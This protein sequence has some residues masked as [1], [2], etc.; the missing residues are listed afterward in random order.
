[1]RLMKLQDDLLF[2]IDEAVAINEM[3]YDKYHDKVMSYIRTQISINEAYLNNDIDSD[4]FDQLI[5]EYSKSETVSIAGRKAMR[6]GKDFYN[7]IREEI[8]KAAKQVKGDGVSDKVGGVLRFTGIGAAGAARL[9]GLILAGPLDYALNGAIAC[10]TI[11]LNKFDFGLTTPTY[12][13]MTKPFIDEIR[14]RH[15]KKCEGIL[16]TAR[17]LKERAQQIRSDADEGKIT[18]TQ[19]E[20]QVETLVKDTLS[21]AK[22]ID[23]ARASIQ[24][25]IDKTV[26][27]MEKIKKQRSGVTDGSPEYHELKHKVETLNKVRERY[28]SEVKGKADIKDAF[29][30]TRNESIMTKYANRYRIKEKSNGTYDKKDCQVILS[31]M[32]KDSA[33]KE[34][35]RA[36]R[37]YMRSL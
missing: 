36:V 6:M 7:S 35:I 11:P 2:A 17:A 28:D 24:N 19:A 5:Y 32:L 13:A 30:S 29:N 33:P 22:S 34:D 14:D 9:A 21:L 1:M 25:E 3:G 12:K 8:I 26:V 20:K 27:K 15:S 37:S 16:D 10:V 4:Q 23:K 31:E 18:A